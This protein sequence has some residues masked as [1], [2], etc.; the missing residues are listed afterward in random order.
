MFSL[1]VSFLPGEQW[2]KPKDYFVGEQEDK[3]RTV[4][5]FFSKLK[6]ISSTRARARQLQ[7]RVVA[8]RNQTGHVHV[9]DLIPHSF[10]KQCRSCRTLARWCNTWMNAWPFF[11]HT[12]TWMWKKRT[13]LKAASLS[14]SRSL[15]AN[16]AALSEELYPPCRTDELFQA[17]FGIFVSLLVVIGTALA[18][19]LKN[20]RNQRRVQVSVFFEDVD[21]LFQNFSGVLLK[22]VMRN[23][24]FTYSSRALDSCLSAELA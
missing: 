15:Q 2:Q 7:T 22:K 1:S 21:H 14:L 24:G 13:G 12:K 19:F 23:L 20:R 8:R 16:A 5:H 3:L 18:F 17:M 9:H 11:S 6:S 10:Q 4:F